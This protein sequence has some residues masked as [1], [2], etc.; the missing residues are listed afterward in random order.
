MS[1]RRSPLVSQ[2]PMEYFEMIFQIWSNIICGDVPVSIIRMPTD[3]DCLNKAIDDCTWFNSMFSST[4]V[5]Q[6]FG[7]A[8]PT[9][10]SKEATVCLNNKEL[11]KIANIPALILRSPLR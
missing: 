4:C 8:C 5:E 9:T 7:V 3:Y 6:S 10:P 2:Q 1:I 11:A